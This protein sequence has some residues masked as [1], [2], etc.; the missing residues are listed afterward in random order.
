MDPDF[1]SLARQVSSGKG[2]V[3]KEWLHE[4]R[5]LE[6]RLEFLRKLSAANE[7]IRA[8]NHD[9]T[10]IELHVQVYGEL[11]L[12]QVVKSQ[13][14]RNQGFLKSLV[15]STHPLYEEYLNIGGDGRITREA[16]YTDI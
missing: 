14:V 9:H 11:G 4:I 10:L 16:E 8:S 1:H 5:G 6:Q 13:I 2:T 15:S 3:L 7:E 12:G